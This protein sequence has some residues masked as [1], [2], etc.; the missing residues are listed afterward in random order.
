MPK[1][2]AHWN[3][4]A[5]ID[6]LARRAPD[7][8]GL[9]RRP[10]PDAL[11]WALHGLPGTPDWAEG[12][13]ITRH[14]G[15][16]GTGLSW[17]LIRS[18]SGRE[19]LWAP[20]ELQNVSEAPDFSTLTSNQRLEVAFLV[21]M[22]RGADPWAWEKTGPAPVR[23]T[24]MLGEFFKRGMLTAARAMI[25]H[26]SFPPYVVTERNTVRVSEP[27]K[28]EVGLSLASA[29]VLSNDFQGLSVLT[30]AG[31]PLWGPGWHDPLA[32][33][34]SAAMARQVLKTGRLGGRDV[35]GAVLGWLLPKS[36]QVGGPSAVALGGMLDEVRAWWRAGGLGE[37]EQ[38]AVQLAAIRAIAHGGSSSVSRVP[39]AQLDEWLHQVGRFDG[40]VWL[41]RV[42]SEHIQLAGVPARVAWRWLVDRSEASTLWGKHPGDRLP[43]TPWH[44]GDRVERLQNWRNFEEGLGEKGSMSA[45]ESAWSRF[46]SWVPPMESWSVDDA[47]QVARL[48]AM[49]R[50]PA[51]WPP[52]HWKLD[53]M[54]EGFLESLPAPVRQVAGTAFAL[55]IVDNAGAIKSSRLS[56]SAAT[57][58][59][60]FRVRERMRWLKSWLQTPG[61]TPPELTPIREKILLSW[62]GTSKSESNEE[63]ARAWKARRLNETLGSPS[64]SSP[65]SRF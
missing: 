9:A 34:R 4:P 47:H 27:G 53:Q 57:F 39:Q 43:G 20:G 40:V 32:C 61:W 24:S 3:C 45:W 10:S 42:G 29:L 52:D 16:L 62:P 60:G 30:D 28:D 51:N 44:E 54:G 65:R 58:W 55:S 18:A 50:T 46:W 64:P 15:G 17:S 22:R 11:D 35:F 59:W 56:V 5:W 41:P 2:A 12:A 13:H 19:P 7:P 38:W 37:E 26:P 14:M 49:E 48:W 21:A 63:L 33:S 6:E 23:P 31:Q 36:P 25:A 8:D 1:S